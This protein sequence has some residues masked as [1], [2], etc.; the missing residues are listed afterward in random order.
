[1]STGCHPWDQIHDRD[2][3]HDTCP[4]KQRSSCSAT[5]PGRLRFQLAYHRIDGCAVALV[6]RVEVT[7]PLAV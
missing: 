6:T 2:Q 7:V 1:M 4:A 3:I 5:R